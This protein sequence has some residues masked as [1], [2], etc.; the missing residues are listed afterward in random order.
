MFPEK[1]KFRLSEALL[2]RAEILVSTVL[3]QS[4]DH[5]A[6]QHAGS[7]GSVEEEEREPPVQLTGR[8]RDDAFLPMP[9]LDSG[10][11]PVESFSNEPNH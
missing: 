4:S 11:R 5:A 9:F 1:F 8:V 2:Y 7:V 3:F 6:V 10:F